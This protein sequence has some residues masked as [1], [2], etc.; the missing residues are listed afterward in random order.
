MATV[1][2]DDTIRDLYARCDKRSNSTDRST[3]DICESD[4]SCGT[5][6]NHY[7]RP[8]TVVA[9]SHF[10][11]DDFEAHLPGG[12]FDDAEGSFVAARVQVFGFRF[13]DVHH[14]FARDFADF[15]FVR[16]F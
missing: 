9:L 7:R 12:A 10:L 15:F 1:A 5:P 16:F 2:G 8:A 3:H 4:A 13:D 6:Y 11:I 14:L